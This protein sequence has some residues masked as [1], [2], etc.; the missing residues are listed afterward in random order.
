MH[1]EAPVFLLAVEAQEN[2]DVW[3]VIRSKFNSRHRSI[4]AS[5]LSIVLT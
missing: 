1:N 3:D 4:D 5:V 2:S